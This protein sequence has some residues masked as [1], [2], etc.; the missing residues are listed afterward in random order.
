MQLKPKLLE[1][2][3]GS[4]SRDGDIN[5]YLHV[6]SSNNL[7]RVNKE[8]EVVDGSRPWVVHESV[9]N[10]PPFFLSRKKRTGGEVGVESLL[11]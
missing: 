5:P 10:L 7:S 11:E 3:K 8:I 6:Y 9:R 1:G 4:V 2:E